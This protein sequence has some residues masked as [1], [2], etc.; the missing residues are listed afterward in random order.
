MKC[1]RCGKRYLGAAANGNGG[2]YRYYVCFSRQRYGRATCD[3]D[4]LPA[5]ELEQ[6]ILDQLQDLLAREDDVREA[7]TAAFAD[8]NNQQ[9]KRDAELARIDAD[10]REG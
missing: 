9:P 6:A 4:S 10:I 8:L 3:A 1:V 7:I 5:D 2:R